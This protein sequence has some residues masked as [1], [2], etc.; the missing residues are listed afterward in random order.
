MFVFVSVVL[1]VKF[2]AYKQQGSDF[3]ENLI[4][5]YELIDFMN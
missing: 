1:L 2:T 3:Q 5:L 4:Q